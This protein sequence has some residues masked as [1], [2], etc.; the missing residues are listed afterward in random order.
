MESESTRMSAPHEVS[1]PPCRVI[2]ASAIGNFVEWF[3]FAVYGFRNADR[4]PVLCQR[5]FQRRLAQDLCRVRGGLRLA[6]LGGIVFGALGDRLG[7][8][9]ILSLTILLMAGSTTLIGL[10]PTLR[11]HRPG[12][13]G[14]A[15]LGALPA[16]FSPVANTPG[17]APT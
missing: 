2:A 13:A 4:Q 1:P 10:L 7:R 17:P 8:K 11:Q 9:R 3:D 5:R 14:I 6:P 12:R 15:D 16:G